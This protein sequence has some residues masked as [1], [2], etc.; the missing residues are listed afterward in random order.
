M[1]MLVAA[2]REYERGYFML[3]D[4]R[5]LDEPRPSQ[6]TCDRL[7]ADGNL[8]ES[9]SSSPVISPKGATTQCHPSQS[10][11]RSMLVK[12]AKRSRDTEALLLASLRPKRTKVEEQWLKQRPECPGDAQ[13]SCNN[14]S[15]TTHAAGVH[16]AEAS[17][18][19]AIRVPDTAC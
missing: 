1:D 4:A 19:V 2:A 8:A 6:F 7:Q 5:A 15:M 12:R 10:V 16:A 14:R 18:P 13:Y 17:P 3:E 9:V 11:A